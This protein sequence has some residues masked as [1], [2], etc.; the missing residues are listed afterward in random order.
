M[1][2]PFKDWQDV[3]QKVT[4]ITSPTRREWQT[5]ER[6]PRDTGFHVCRESL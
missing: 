4:P 2:V 1:A 6:K 3:A 5:R